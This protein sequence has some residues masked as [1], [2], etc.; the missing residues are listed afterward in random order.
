[1]NIR[2]G[3]PEYLLILKKPDQGFYEDIHFARCEI[4][5]SN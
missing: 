3:L 2:S 1:M 4:I 5:F